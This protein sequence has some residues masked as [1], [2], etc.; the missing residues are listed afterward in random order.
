MYLEWSVHLSDHSPPAP[1]LS[2][3]VQT[4][5]SGDKDAFWLELIVFL[6]GQEDM[7]PCAC[8]NLILTGRACQSCSA[9]ALL[10]AVKCVSVFVLERSGEG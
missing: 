5:I 8:S 3:P 4:N 1:L 10:L 7:G 6:I 2:A 9:T